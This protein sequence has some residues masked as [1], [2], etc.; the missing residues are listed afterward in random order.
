MCEREG[1]G[2]S[3]VGVMMQ[4]T[5]PS[6]D[7]SIEGNK[8]LNMTPILMMSRGSQR[9]LHISVFFYINPDNPE[10]KL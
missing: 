8:V 1:V 3:S 2:V 6:F 10:S 9:V 7:T 4:S 5:S